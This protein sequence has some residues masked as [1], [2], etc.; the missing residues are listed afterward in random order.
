MVT[1]VRTF[2]AERVAFAEAQGL[3]KSQIAV[4][5]GIGFGKTVEHNLELL[6]RLEELT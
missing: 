6:A 5:P 4:D 2:L 1:E 3:K